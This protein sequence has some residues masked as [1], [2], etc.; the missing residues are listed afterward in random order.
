VRLAQHRQSALRIFCDFEHRLLGEHRLSDRPLALG[1]LLARLGLQ[2]FVDDVKKRVVLPQTYGERDGQ[3]GSADDQAT[4][5]L[6]EVVH[7]A[8]SILV[9]NRANRAGHG[10]HEPTTAPFWPS[11]LAWP[12]GRSSARSRPLVQRAKGRGPEGR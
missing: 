9:A 3:D 6:I 12:C 2:R 8:E 7:E 10:L 5:Q 4:A 1:D 11:P